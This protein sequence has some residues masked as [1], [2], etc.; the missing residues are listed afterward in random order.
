M[1]QRTQDT[2]QKL[3]D[4]AREL[5]AERG[6]EGVS[7]REITRAAG[8]ANVNALQYHFGGRAPLLAAVLEPFHR[9]VDGLR[10]AQLDAIEA[11]RG[12]SLRDF[13]GALVR[14][15]AA[16]L[17]VEGGREYLRILGEL[18]RDPARHGNRAVGFRSSLDRWRKLVTP[19]MPEDVTPLHRRF[20]AIHLAASELARRAELRRRRDDRLFVSDLVDLVAGVLA[21]PV[22]DETRGLLEARHATRAAAA[23]QRR[24]E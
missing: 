10:H 23:R 21:A 14:P 5:L 3:I 20:A 24:T 12:P 19:H 1:D 16:M 6:V 15:S 7:L 9:E 4:A 13:A 8:Q 22:S 17:R 2:R 18:V 11:R